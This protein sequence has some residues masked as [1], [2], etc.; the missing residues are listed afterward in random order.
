MLEKRDN[1]EQ[2]RTAEFLDLLNQY[3]GK[4]N[5]YVYSLVKDYALADDILQDSRMVMWKNFDQFESGTNFLAWSRKV[6]FHQIL[7]ARKKVKKRPSSLSDELLH[8]I[9]DEIEQLDSDSRQEAL[10]Q[11]IKKLSETH[12][13]IVK[14]RYFDNLEIEDISKSVQRPAG[15]V[16]RVLSRIRTGLGECIQKRLSGG[17]A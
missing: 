4:L 14:L 17:L 11:C 9:A 7:S 5:A 6:V 12:Q 8:S 10:H 2:D 16:Y 1:L 3:E 13:Q 15:G